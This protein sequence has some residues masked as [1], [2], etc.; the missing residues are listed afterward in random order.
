MLVHVCAVVR[1]TARLMGLAKVF[2]DPESKIPATISHQPLPFPIRDRCHMARR[3]GNGIFFVA[4][5]Q[6]GTWQYD[7]W[8]QWYRLHTAGCLGYGTVVLAARWGSM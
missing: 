2:V 5:V 4:E 7:T 1:T 6:E 3:V 8:L